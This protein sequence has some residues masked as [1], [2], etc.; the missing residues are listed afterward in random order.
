MFAIDC[1]TGVLVDPRDARRDTKYSCPS[2]SGEVIFAEGEIQVAHFRHKSLSTDCTHYSSSESMVHLEAKQMLTRI[3][4]ERRCSIEIERECKKCHLPFGTLIEPL[5]PTTV[6]IMEWGFEHNGRRRRADIACIQEDGTIEM[7]F[8]ICHT[9]PTMCE[10]RPEPWYELDATDVRSALSASGNIKKLRCI[11][12]TFVENKHSCC[13]NC[14]DGKIFFNQRGAGC[15]KTYES[16]QLLQGEQFADKNVFIYLTKMNSAKVVIYNELMSQFHR[17]ALGSLVLVDEQLNGNQFV[18][19]FRQEESRRNVAVL[20]GT[21]DSFTYA[22]KKRS[23]SFEGPSMFKQ[24]VNDISTGNMTIGSDGSIA[25]ARTKPR[26]TSECL[27]VIDEAQDLEDDYIHAF[28]KIIDR[29]GIDTYIIGDKLQ[30]ILSEENLFTYLACAG[31]RNKRLI[32]DVGKNIVKRFHNHHFQPFVNSLVRFEHYGLPPIEGICRDEGACYYLHDDNIPFVIDLDMPTIYKGKN[33]KMEEKFDYIERLTADVCEK[34]ARHG[35]LPNN[36]CFIFPVV[37]R[38][39]LIAPL[40]EVALQ[41]MWEEI[42][43][44]P[45]SYTADF[46]R[47][48]EKNPEYWESKLENRENDNTSFLHVFR[49]SAELNGSVDLT[50]SENGTRIMSIHASKGTGCECVYL[51]GISEFNLTVFTGGIPNT[52]V[53]ESLLHVGLTRQKKYLRIG[54]CDKN[55][56]IYRRFVG[57]GY[58]DEPG[59]TSLVNLSSNVYRSIV[60]HLKNEKT[61]SHSSGTDVDRF[62]DREYYRQIMTGNCRMIRNIDWGH[63]IIRKAVMTTNV[64]RHLVNN[65]SFHHINLKHQT[66]VERSKHKFVSSYSEY[67]QYL[68]ELHNTIVRNI[69]NKGLNAMCII[70]FLTFSAHG[71][72]ASASHSMFNPFIRHLCETVIIKLRREIIDFCPIESLMYSHMMDLVQHPF[73][74][75][76]GIMDIYRLVSYYHKAGHDHRNYGCECHVYIPPLVR[77]PGSFKPHETIINSIVHHYDMIARVDELIDQLPSHCLENGRVYSVGKKGKLPIKDVGELS[78]SR[79]DFISVDEVSSQT[80]C[81][82]LAP[83]LNSMNYLEILS[84]I[85]METF[86]LKQATIREKNKTMMVEYYILSLDCPEPIRVDFNEIVETSDFKNGFIFPFI[87]SHFERKHADICSFV[88]NQMHQSQTFTSVI[89]VFTELPTKYIAE[90]LDNMDEEGDYDVEGNLVRRLDRKLKRKL[91]SAF[92]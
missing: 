37:N 57:A 71:R 30:S 76:V 72:G 54:I 48:M 38:R 25:Y 10:N 68:N 69:K 87:K 11:R 33:E 26:L 34:V 29:T 27:I 70:P 35:Y 46:V 56:D 19:N 73:E 36:F 64:N 92:S 81:L 4:E 12:T 89:D 83:Q 31:A 53:Y 1:H 43:T 28:D 17:G 20:I 22:L 88:L 6:P 67:K 9:N 60:D 16:I 18:V 44:D 40:L 45:A 90:C 79:I 24:I 23:S 39:N 77:G 55:D 3:L 49:H 41:N 61:T 84:N 78:S 58:A 50:E 15:G 13:S 51:L 86:I 5:D 63:H 62:I 8:E 42:F 7:I 85:L 14:G 32:K 47:N 75:D 52:L 82:R 59:T 65:T 66:L 74:L 91:E 2:C 21:I 80:I